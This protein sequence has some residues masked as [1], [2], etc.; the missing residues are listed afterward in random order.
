MMEH[1]HEQDLYE[2]GVSLREQYPYQKGFS[3]A[4]HPCKLHQEASTI[5]FGY[6]AINYRLCAERNPS[7][8]EKVAREAGRKWNAGG[9]VGFGTQKQTFEDVKFQQVFAGTAI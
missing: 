5:P 9:K 4:Y 8:G 7:P 2:L 3:V 6:T 1:L